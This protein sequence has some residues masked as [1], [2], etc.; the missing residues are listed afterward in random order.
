MPL[1]AQWESLKIVIIYSVC[2]SILNNPDFSGAG[3]QGE[4]GAHGGCRNPALAL[5]PRS[6]LREAVFT[7][8]RARAAETEPF[9][10]GPGGAVRC[11]PQRPRAA[12]RSKA[13]HPLAAPRP[14]V[15]A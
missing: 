11:F 4:A 5:K 3:S 10:A 6:G 15:S 9:V 8:I 13:G 2:C 7:Q 14:P 12:E 1:G